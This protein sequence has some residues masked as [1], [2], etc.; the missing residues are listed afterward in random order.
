VKRPKRPS[1]A[2]QSGEPLADIVEIAG[3]EPANR[4][5]SSATVDAAHASIA[6]NAADTDSLTDAGGQ[7]LQ[8][9]AVEL[10]TAE[11][12]T[13]LL[14][15]YAQV[16]NGLLHVVGGAITRITRADYPGPFG[17]NVAVVADVPYE[18]VGRLLP[19]SVVLIGEAGE[20]SRWQTELNTRWEGSPGEWLAV[21]FVVPSAS[22][23]IPS[24]GTYEVQIEVAGDIKRRLGFVAALSG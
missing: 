8:S 16:R 19:V 9:S 12:T 24:A 2:R 17:V 3:T 10:T 21:P 5:A 1:R 6:A 18:E 7:A 20:V 4:D 23:V 22:T 14:C 11:L 13:A 15:D